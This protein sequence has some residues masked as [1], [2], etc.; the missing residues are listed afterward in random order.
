MKKISIAFATAALMIASTA[1]ASAQTY[2]PSGAGNGTGR[3]QQGQKGKRIGR[4]DG[5]GP[6]HTPGTG[7]GNGGGQRR[8]RR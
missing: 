5:S 8:G 7:G 2:P 1:D 3:Q 6:L 4:K